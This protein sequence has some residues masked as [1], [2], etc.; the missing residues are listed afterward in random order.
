MFLLVF[1]SFSEVN[2]CPMTVPQVTKDD[3][4]NAPENMLALRGEILS[5]K[6]NEPL[7]SFPHKGM[8]I[9]MKILEKYQGEYSKNII[10]VD[11]GG[12]HSPPGKS[13]DIIYALA[14]KHPVW[15][16]GWYAPQFWKKQNSD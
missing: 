9:Q 6:P 5:I 1:F 15:W 11:Y 12:C 14:L 3:I 13:G 16:K 4:E 8:I 2:A 7:D 10:T